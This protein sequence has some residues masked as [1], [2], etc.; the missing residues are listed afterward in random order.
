M[1]GFFI[2]YFSLLVSTCKAGGTD[3][4]IGP[5]DN[6][7]KAAH[8]IYGLKHGAL[9]VRL[10]TNDKSVDAYR[11]AG[12]NTLADKIVAERAEKNLKIVEAFKY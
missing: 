11:K 5:P 7:F 3:S 4:L 8:E 1:R 2:I 9:V 12:Q 6:F 10:K